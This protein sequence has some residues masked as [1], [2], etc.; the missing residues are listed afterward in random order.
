MPA[1]T[2]TLLSYGTV[3]DVDMDNTNDVNF[4]DIQDYGHRVSVQIEKAKLNEIF[5]WVRLAG[6]ARPSAKIGTTS[7]FRTALIDALASTYTDIDGVTGGLHFGSAIMDTNSDARIRKDDTVSANDIPMAFVLYKLY[8]NSAV[9]TLNNIFNLQDA[10]DMLTNETV[11][12]A[13]IASLEDE[14]AG[15]VDIM[16]RDLL[17]ADPARFFNASGVPQTGIFETNT[18]VSGNGTWNIV[19]DDVIEIKTKLV[20]K[21]KITR[22]GAAG[23]EV[24]LTATDLGATQNNQQTIINPNDYFYIRLQLKAADIGITSSLDAA[25]S[26]TTAAAFSSALTTLSSNLTAS[27]RSTAKTDLKTNMTTIKTNLGGVSY[28]SVSGAAIQGFVTDYS[29]G[30]DVTAKEKIFL[31]YNSGETINLANTTAEDD[32]AAGTKEIYLFGLPGE[33]VTLTLS[34]GSYTLTTTSTGVTYNGTNYALGSNIVLGTFTFT[35]NFLG[36]GG[37]TLRT[38]KPKQVS[39]MV[40]WLDASDD[41][42][43]STS[44]GNITQ[45]RDKSTAANHFSVTSGTT[46]TVT[47]GSK[48]TVYFPLNSVMAQGTN[49]T[50]TPNVTHMFI[51]L[52]KEGAS[53]IHRWQNYTT[54]GVNSLYVE[55]VLAGGPG[56]GA[57]GN[58][59]GGNNYRVNGSRNAVTTSTFT[60]YHIISAPYSLGSVI[61][62]KFAIGRSSEGYTGKV[63]EIILYNNAMDLATKQKIEGYL[64]WKWGLTSTL[65]NDFPW[66][67]APPY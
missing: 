67:N 56:M 51:V 20:F 6:A 35:L 61:T 38:F 36:S 65:P 31:L 3:V 64:A 26:A 41:S 23:G 15:A 33:T 5:K 10:H 24:N 43:I 28:V 4:A 62:D 1:A 17:A 25:K 53:Y 52:K 21:S 16:F 45:W 54:T 2:P 22:R 58:D 29:S 30:Y 14:E 8:G 47:D 49:M 34:S 27:N 42:T 12:D 46:Q 18:D 66:K 40:T 50:V 60:N 32:L 44:G 63:C 55:G 48:K 11:A 57:G 59:F 39:N 7:G 37:G 19:D 13:I 9:E